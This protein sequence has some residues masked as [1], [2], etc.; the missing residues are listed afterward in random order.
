[1]QHQAHCFRLTPCECQHCEETFHIKPSIWSVLI[2]ADC[3][4]SL[5]NSHRS[6]C[7]LAGQDDEEGELSQHIHDH[8]LMT[9]WMLH[10]HVDLG[11][12]KCWH[13]L[14]CFYNNCTVLIT[15]K[16]HDHTNPWMCSTLLPLTLDHGKEVNQ[17]LCT[18]M[19]VATPN[20][21]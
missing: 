12:R 6:F 4:L 20:R 2:R 5:W 18:E 10:R 8:C 1:M 11:S 7:L 19:K 14:D 15:M 9:F 3:C 16:S 21:Q 13:G 17:M